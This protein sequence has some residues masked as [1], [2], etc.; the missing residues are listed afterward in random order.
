VAFHNLPPSNPDFVGREEVLAKLH[1]LLMSSQGP[2][3]ITQTITGLGGVGKTQTVLAYAYRHLADYRLVWWLRAESAATLA[4]DFAGLAGPLGI[5]EQPEQA[6][7]VTAI[8]AKLQASKGWLLVLDNIEDPELPRTYLP[9]TGSGHVLITSR[10]T[11]WH[12]IA[13]ALPLEVMGEVEALQLLTGRPHPEI[14]PPADLAEAKALAKE[15]GYLPLA[16]T[17]ARA[18][19]AATGKSLAGYLRLFRDSRP[20]DFADDQPSPDYPDS[21]VTTWRISIDAAASACP[22]A[23]PLLE[24]LA[25]LAAD[26]LPVEA[27]GA[28]PAALPDGLRRERERDAAIAALHRYS[29]IS[30]AADWLTIHRLVQAV[31]RDGLD[32]ATAMV[33]AGAAVRLVNAALPDRT[34]DPTNWPAFGTLLPHALAVADAAEQLRS[35]LKAVARVLNQT[36]L[37]QKA[38]AAFAEAA[39]LYQRALVIYET[40]LGPEHPRTAISLNNLAGLYR[41][42]G[43][44]DK[45]EPLHQRALAIREK[46][47]GP[48]HPGTATSLNN[49]A[50]LYRA[51]GRLD[52]A[53]PLHQRA[54]AIYKAALGPEHPDTATI[55]NDLAGLYRAQGR[56]D[57]AEPL[58]QRALVIYE[59]LLGPEH[60]YTATSLNNLATLYCD[61]SRL[62][63]AERLYQ[64]ALAIFEKV[65]DAEDRRT[66]K[67]RES[68]AMLRQHLSVPPPDHQPPATSL[69]GTAP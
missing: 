57:E 7:L 63:E 55:L 23:R 58:H 18:Y 67:V 48:E 65:F 2:T 32:E 16:L 36:G 31:T 54:L 68:L 60:P 19:M 46:V 69:P 37:Y 29:L 59:T 50:G 17:Q 42:Q 11:D 1:R 61:Q 51:Q 3:V 40:L 52:E 6:K 43:R 5:P 9:T 64:R 34:Q 49:L 35:S 56:L 14:L 25:F 20:T 30:A 13:K 4:A 22:A 12:G 45:A 26:P 47:L 8:K 66:R 33:R 53:E 41:A 62:D 44:P 39:P 21:Y 38:R 10:R 28:Y 24:L 27:L 15:L